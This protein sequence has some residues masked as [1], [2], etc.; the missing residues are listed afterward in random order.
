MCVISVLTWLFLFSF[1][2]VFTLW[3]LFGYLHAYT[4]WSNQ[5]NWGK[6]I[7]SLWSARME[8]I[9]VGGQKWEIKIIYPE[10]HNISFQW[11][12]RLCPF[13]I[14]AHKSQ[15]S[16]KSMKSR[17]RHTRAHCLCMIEYVYRR[18][19]FIHRT[20]GEQHTATLDLSNHLLI[21]ARRWL[22]KTSHEY[23]L[24]SQPNS[25]IAGHDNLFHSQ[26]APPHSHSLC[27]RIR[28]HVFYNWWNKD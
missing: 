17:H 27:H 3:L 26:L 12:S 22:K 6:R 19:S 8:K 9:R 18:V 5:I 23:M 10:A 13:E 15:K 16:N 14:W 21:C 4:K 2:K 25:S 24:A 20:R 28:R 11:R 1:S 7:I